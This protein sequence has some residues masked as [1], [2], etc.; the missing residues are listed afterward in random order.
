MPIVRVDN[1]NKKDI[2][3]FHRKFKKFFN[4]KQF[5]N[6]TLKNVIRNK[7][8]GKLFDDFLRYHSMDWLR[9]SKT[10]NKEDLS[11]LIRFLLI[12]YD[13]NDYL[14]FLRDHEKAAKDKLFNNMINNNNNM[15]GEN[16][17]ENNNNINNQN[18]DNL[19]DID[20]EDDEDDEDNMVPSVKVS[21]SSGSS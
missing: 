5:N 14:V 10:K 13:N 12:C 18:A 4:G 1:P 9:Q 19:C 16:N 17:N 2:D 20:D 15:I 3:G 6:N 7:L 8:Y 21:S 11:V